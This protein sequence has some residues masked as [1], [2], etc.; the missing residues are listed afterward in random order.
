MSSNINY[1]PLFVEKIEEFLEKCP[2][3]TLGELLYCILTQ[4]SKSNTPV[5]T[6]GDAL[7]ISDKDLYASVCKAIKEE[8]GGDEPIESV[9]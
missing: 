9:Q 6:R 2:E 5:D 8:S 1:K 7:N 3:Y 4:L